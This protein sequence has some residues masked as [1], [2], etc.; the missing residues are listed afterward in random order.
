MR[1]ITKTAIASVAIAVCAF[2]TTYVVLTIDMGGLRRD[3]LN[4]GKVLHCYTPAPLPH[5]I[6]HGLL[7]LATA[8]VVLLIGSGVWRICTKD[9]HAA[10]PLLPQ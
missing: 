8:P 6:G 9:G 4:R 2:A 10:S 5:A 7:A 3:R 1:Y